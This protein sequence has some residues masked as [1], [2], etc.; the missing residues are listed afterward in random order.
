MQKPL[1]DPKDTKQRI[2]GL[3]VGLPTSAFLFTSLIGF[4]MAQLAS[5]VVYPFS[6]KKSAFPVSLSRL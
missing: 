6:K 5:L 4:N 2:V 1:D 3:S